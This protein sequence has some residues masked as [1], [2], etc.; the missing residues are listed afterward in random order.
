MN[1]GKVHFR[2]IRNFDK[3]NITARGGRT[4]AFR[5]IDENTIEFAI[6]KCSPK[7]NFNKKIGRRI[8][9]GRLNSGKV[10]VVNETWDYFMENFYNAYYLF[11]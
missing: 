3:K 9:E 4:I 8:A 7:D 2:H 5:Q 10:E 6:A 1:Q 11:N